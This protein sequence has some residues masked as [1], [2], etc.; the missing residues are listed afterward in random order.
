MA[1]IELLCGE[2]GGV[3]A[4]WYIWQATGPIGPLS[5]QDLARSLKAGEVS[6]DDWLWH[7]RLGQWT[8]AGEIDFLWP[9]RAEDGADRKQSESAPVQAAVPSAGSRETPSLTALFLS[10]LRQQRG[11][12]QAVE[13]DAA[14]NGGFVDDLAAAAG[15]APEPDPDGVVASAPAKTVSAS[16][17]L[18]SASEGETP[19]AVLTGRKPPPLPTVAGGVAQ[20]AARL[21]RRPPPLPGG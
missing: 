11:A 18:S 1:S 9:Q 7:E 4:G 17:Y 20:P 16:A 5:N 6:R 19:R 10:R 3:V 8:A 15:T 13:A 2:R 14:S 12:R 21:G